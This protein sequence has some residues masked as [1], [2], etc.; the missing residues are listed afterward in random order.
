[1]IGYL[2]FGVCA[3]LGSV[4]I[5]FWCYQRIVDHRSGRGRR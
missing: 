5:G 1:L 2:I 4:M 3:V